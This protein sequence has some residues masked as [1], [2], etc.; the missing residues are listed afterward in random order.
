MPPKSTLAKLEHGVQKGNQFVQKARK[1]IKDPNTQKAIKIG[2]GV[3]KGVKAS[4]GVKKYLKENK[5]NIKQM[6]QKFGQG[7]L[8]DLSSRF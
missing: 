1:F 7:A 2:K 6:A 4:G 8:D 3:I 5:G